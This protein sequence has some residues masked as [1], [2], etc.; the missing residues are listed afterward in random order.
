MVFSSLSEASGAELTR[1][2][3]LAFGGAAP[4]RACRLAERLHVD[5]VLVPVDASLGSA[6]GFFSAPLAY[7]A[8]EPC[9]M[10][11]ES[12]FDAAELNGLFRRLWH[13]TVAVVAQG[14]ARWKP[15]RPPK[16]L[17]RA[18]VRYVGQG[19]EVKVSL[20]N[21]DLGPKD[22]KM[23]RESFEKEYERLGLL[24]LPEELEIRALALE[25]VADADPLAWP[26]ERLRA[27][28][29]EKSSMLRDGQLGTL[30]QAFGKRICEDSESLVYRRGDLKLGELIRGP[31]LITE[32]YTTTVVTAS[33]D[34]WL[35]ENGFL[36]LQARKSIKRNACGLPRALHCTG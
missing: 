13:R 33:F 10:R 12:G 15:G 29:H 18:Y 20:P 24:A 35:L 31:A 3:L 9:A 27:Q 4:L 11:L 14:A 36:Q 1:H 28:K 32:T 2:V 7:E 19:Q 8:L 6:V 16:E 17:R 23:I 21:E 26:Q 25:V 22:S 30:A 5:T 34:C